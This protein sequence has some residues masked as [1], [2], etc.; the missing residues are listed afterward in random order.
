M[1]FAFRNLAQI[2]VASEESEPG[3]GWQYDD[4]LKTL[5]DNPS[6]QPEELS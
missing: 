4:W 5:L 1:A 3:D 6:M 2:M